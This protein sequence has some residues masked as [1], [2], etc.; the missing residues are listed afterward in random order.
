MVDL[1]NVDLKWI[2][3]YTFLADTVPADH[4][5]LLDLLGD[6]VP[7]PRAGTLTGCRG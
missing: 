7:S 6:A 5:L 3:V 2:L 4:Q 1:M